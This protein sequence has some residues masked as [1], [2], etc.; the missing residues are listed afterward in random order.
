MLEDVGKEKAPELNRIVG[1][2]QK[3]TISAVERLVLRLRATFERHWG[4][5]AGYTDNKYT[6]L[7]TGH[8]I[9]FIDAVVE[10]VDIHYDR[11][12][13]SRALRK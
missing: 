8:V 9:D 5:D 11:G 1:L 13:I 6:E 7:T 4:I 12:S 10:E 2:K 3:K